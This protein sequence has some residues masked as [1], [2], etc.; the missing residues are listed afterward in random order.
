MQARLILLKK[1]L[2][3]I[4][5]LIFRSKYPSGW[6][7]EKDK[8]YIHKNNKQKRRIIYMCDGFKGHGGLSDRLKSLMSMYIEAQRKKRPFYIYWVAPFSL[9]EFLVPAS[10][11]D[12]EVKR[13]DICYEYSKSFP[14]F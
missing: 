9:K 1:H 11:Y 7:L 4:F 2:Q 13:K 12:W 8:E 14:F 10:E 3:T 6:G 5:Y